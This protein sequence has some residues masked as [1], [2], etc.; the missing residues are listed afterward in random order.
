MK[1]AKVEVGHM[2]RYWNDDFKTLP[3]VK[4]GV[5]KEEVENW[6]R[7]GYSEN[8]VKSYTGSM[9][10][11]SNVMPE[12]ID[13]FENAFGLYKQ[14][15]T[16]YC[17]Q[18][19]EIMPT[20]SDHFSTYCKINNTTPDKVYRAILMLEDWKPGHYFELDGVGYVNWKAGDWF[21]WRG[22][23][24]HAASNIGIEPR[25]TLQVT[26]LDFRVG[27]LNRLFSFNIPDVEEEDNH[28]LLKDISNK[29]QES[30][31]MVYLNNGYI[32]ELDSINH[33]QDVQELLNKEGLHIYMYEPLCSY[34]MQQDNHTQGFYSEFD[35]ISPYDLQAEELD[36]IYVYVRRNN[37]NNVTV[38]TGDYNAGDWYKDYTDRMNLICDDLFLKTQKTIVNI[39]ETPSNEFIYNFICLNWRFTKHRQLVAT[40]LA[41][42]SGHLSWHFKSKFDVLGKDLFFDLAEW[43]EK[44]PTIY[45]RLEQ[46][47]DYISQHSPLCLD[48]RSNRAI[49]VLDPK[50]VE[51]WPDSNEYEPG[52]TPSLYN[53]VSNNLSDY[54]FHVFLDVVNETRFAQPTANISEKTFQPMQY[55]KPFVL[56]APPKSLEY[57]KSLGFKTFSDFWDESYDNE[58][59]HGERLV[60]I[61]QLLDKLFAMSNQEQRDLYNKMLPVLQHNFDRYKD[62][63]L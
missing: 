29:I 17:M 13:R 28:P 39:R 30:H 3:Y 6:E 62:F 47:C 22:D 38:H 4:Q 20:H 8:F 31:Y 58:F 50:Y 48:K 57:V 51:M 1:Q 36:S 16:F 37:L 19:C 41:G 43:K 40:Y 10:D 34:R 11:H 61:F 54:Y 7:L 26:G 52:V 46:G 24:P 49:E 35:D 55:F 23:V 56:V 18:T 25:Y 21:K 27:Q 63:V 44:Y 42:Q 60:K 2:G 45:Q 12:W 14:S 15:Y 33:S 5:T 53:Q 9:Y 59:D 32:T